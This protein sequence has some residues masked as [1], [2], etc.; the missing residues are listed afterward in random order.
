MCHMTLSNA[1]R[2]KRKRIRQSILAKHPDSEIM[3]VVAVKI[4]HHVG[5]YDPDTGKLIG[6]VK[7]SE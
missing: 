6:S 3:D 1:D 7:V 2:Q 4:G 5:L